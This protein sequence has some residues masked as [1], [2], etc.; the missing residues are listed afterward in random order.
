MRGNPVE[1]MPQL[2]GWT[3]RGRCFRFSV[4]QLYRRCVGGLC[5]VSCP[6]QLE[7]A[8]NGSD[9]AVCHSWLGTGSEIIPAL[10][11]RLQWGGC[12]RW[13]MFPSVV[14]ALY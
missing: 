2:S 7:T 6:A 14:Y 9:W 10:T 13:H 5:N 8:W 4:C 12:R 11:L 1:F 3:Y